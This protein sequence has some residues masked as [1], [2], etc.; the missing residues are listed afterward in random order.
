MWLLRSV[1]AVLIELRGG[2]PRFGREFSRG[3]GQN[4]VVRTG[5]RTAYEYFP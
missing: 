2:S 4:F 5:P 1:F 3:S